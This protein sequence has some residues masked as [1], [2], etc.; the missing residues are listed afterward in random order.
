MFAKIIARLSG[1]SGRPRDPIAAVRDAFEDNSFVLGTLGR[2]LGMYIGWH[3]YSGVAGTIVAHRATPRGALISPLLEKIGGDWHRVPAVRKALVHRE[4]LKERESGRVG[5]LETFFDRQSAFR[6]P[7]ERELKVVL[8]QD[9][10][11]AFFLFYWLLQRHVDRKGLRTT[12]ANLETVVHT[13]AAELSLLD[14]CQCRTERHERLRS[15]LGT[16]MQE[17]PQLLFRRG[18]ERGPLERAIAATLRSEDDAFLT[19]LARELLGNHHLTAAEIASSARFN[20]F[21]HYALRKGDPGNDKSIVYF[22]LVMPRAKDHPGL[23][24]IVTLDGLSRQPSQ[25][26][27]AHLSLVESKVDAILPYALLLGIMFFGDIMA[28]EEGSLVRLLASHGLRTPLAQLASRAGTLLRSPDLPASLAGSVREI[29]GLAEDADQLVLVSYN[30]VASSER[31]LIVGTRQ[32]AFLTCGAAD[33]PAH[34]PRD[35]ARVFW[36]DLTRVVT[37]TAEGLT[38]RADLSKLQRDLAARVAQGAFSLD[39]EGSGS[40]GFYL[41]HQGRLCGCTAAARARTTL[42]GFVLP[43]LIANA[44]KEAARVSNSSEL[45]VRV[46]LSKRR[47]RITVAMMGN[48]ATSVSS[49]HSLLLLKDKPTGSRRQLGLFLS[50]QYASSLGWHL[51]KL[52][53]RGGLVEATLSLPALFNNRSHHD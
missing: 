39:H 23:F 21:G 42:L 43:E 37:S 22:P 34:L 53:Q 17:E 26:P 14:D 51:E 24:F 4:F 47:I 38:A 45:Y 25:N 20:V 32:P 41:V 5:F 3:Y 31:Q 40:P 16:A 9:G 36:S 28:R 29:R 19:A 10:E 11:V 50:A 30:L 13:T 33:H 35:A 8:C 49:G 15:W 46:R 48:L 7:L 18:P 52:R 44:I 12:L 27:E 1:I 6:T 2:R